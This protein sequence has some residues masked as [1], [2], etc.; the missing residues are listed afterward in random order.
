MNTSVIV[1]VTRV[2]V[3]CALFVMATLMLATIGP[4]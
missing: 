4:G 1:A 2:V 3:N